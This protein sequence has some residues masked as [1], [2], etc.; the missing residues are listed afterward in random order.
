M[1]ASALELLFQVERQP[2]KKTVRG[3]TKPAMHARP[4]NASE[5]PFVVTASK[6]FVRTKFQE[7]GT[8]WTGF[9]ECELEEEGLATQ[10]L[11]RDLWRISKREDWGNRCSS[12]ADAMDLAVLLGFTPHTIVVPLSFVK[13]AVGEDLTLEEAEK[14]MRMQGYLTT[15]DDARVLIGDLL[16]D[17]AL[18]TCSP[19]ELGVYVRTD[20]FVAITLLGA[21][22]RLVLVG[23]DG[24]A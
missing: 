17:T 13:E 16:D 2:P 19:A 22:R 23:P 18:V 24:V 11:H 8:I 7:D 14:I 15:I 20:D 3:M 21:D 9:L 12:L 5:A 1:R 10:L 6:G 4:Y